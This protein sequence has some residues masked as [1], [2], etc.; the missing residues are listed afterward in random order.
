MPTADH[1]YG[2][3]IAWGWRPYVR[4]FWVDAPLVARNAI[5]MPYLWSAVGILYL[6]DAIWSWAI[7]LTLSSYTAFVVMIC[8]LLLATVLLR[9]KQR[10][11]RLAV[12]MEVWALW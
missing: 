3:W 6:T 1:K 7:G 4:N 11:P 12:A 2:M 5:H 9:G 10:N 8:I